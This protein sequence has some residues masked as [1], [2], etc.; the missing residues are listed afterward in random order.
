[1]NRPSPALR[2]LRRGFTLLEVVVGL[3]I[4]SLGL[5]VL[6]DTQAS[7][8]LST[9][10]GNKMLIATELAE[11]KLAEVMLLVEVEGFTEDDKSEE[12]DFEEYGEEDWRGDGLDLEIEGLEEFHYAW[13]VRKIELTLPTDLASMMGDLEG[14]GFLPEEKTGEDFDASMAPD[15][16]DF[17]ISSDMIADYLGD[18]IREVRVVVWW[19]SE[20]PDVDE[21]GQLPEDSIELLTHVINPTGKINPPLGGS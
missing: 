18:Y 21:P 11:E 12:G 6:V 14:V 1:M 10:E 7:S 19:G 5:M 4:L 3:G 16:G 13:T 17:G 8:V 20:E 15:L 9:V 2:S